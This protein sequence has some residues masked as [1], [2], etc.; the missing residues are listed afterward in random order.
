MARQ[1]QRRGTAAAL[2]AANELPLAGQIYVEYVDANTYRIKVGN[3][4]QRY[5]DL[6]YLSSNPGIS[7]VAGLTAALAGKQA[8]GS[9]AAQSHSHVA[10]NISDFASAVT[11]VAPPTVDASLLTTGTLSAA[12]LPASVVLTTDSRL[13]DARTPSSHTHGNITNAGSI[14][15][16]SGQI[17]VTGTSGA[18]TTAAQ[19]SASSVSGLATVATTGS[20]NDLSNKPTIPAA[21]TLPN[22]TTTTL[23]GVIVGT[24]LGVSSGT[25]SVTYGT[26]ASTACQGNDARLS[27]ARTPLTHVHAASDITSGVIAAARLGTGIADSTTFLRGDGTWQVGTG[28]SGSGI[29]QADADVRYVNTAGDT[30]TGNLTVSAT[31]DRIV[32]VTSTS[33]GSASIN[34]TSGAST[35]QLSQLG[36]TLFATNFASGGILA[37]TQAGA[38]SIRL[39]VNSVIALNATDTTLTTP[40]S[41]GIGT[42][43]P[44]TKLH[45]SDTAA[46]PQ[47]LVTSANT[48]TGALLFGDTDSNVT[49]GRIQYNHQFD[50][51]QLFANNAERVRILDVGMWVYPAGSASQPS[52]A[53]GND[54]NTG[55]WFPA[56]DT[57]AVSTG[58]VER[59]RIDSTGIT[60][61][62]GALTAQGAVTGTT[63]ISTG[64]R[65]L[66][67][68]GLTTDALYPIGVRQQG[69]G[70]VYFG[71][72]DAT[73]TPG[74]QISSA[75]GGAMISC[76]NAGAV[77][78]PGS[79]SVAGN[80]VVVTNDFRL[81][82]ARSPLAHVHGNIT[83][84][85]AIGST[86]G[87]IVV[88][89][90]SGVLTT[91]A[92][93]A[94]ASVSG[95]SAVA[96]SGNYNDLTNKPSASSR[97]LIF[98]LN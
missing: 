2:A 93:I 60:T 43:A 24:G 80:A 34:V 54:T 19:I 92:T 27:D 25:V 72:T 82:D 63:H 42:T 96:T 57:I 65:S 50:V 38:G 48:S 16:T 90:A 85:G 30:M 39:Q 45:V 71:A 14:G 62:S 6:P 18:L 9:Y 47:I 15:T 58:G 70:Y 81:T 89:G 12:R 55:L 49:G 40:G 56:A 75:G 37:F 33:A 87:Q 67:T 5:N 79:L 36:T 29:T 86:S 44:T 61:L 53:N 69:G 32:A 4:T 8:A 52:I 76:T 35:G 46:A 78:I 20:Y 83:N 21:Y 91:A 77:S 59:L 23:G 1:Q 66:F 95:L 17:V 3:G 7:E 64:G 74:M 28:G 51:L 26:A 13:S 11:T 94:A 97:A 98:A 88:T 10:A 41:V 84:A 68:A 22:A 31:G 73:A